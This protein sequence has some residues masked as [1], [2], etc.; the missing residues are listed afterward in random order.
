MAQ[1][2]QTLLVDDIDGSPAKETVRFS[3]DGAEYEI[4]V[5]SEHGEELR[6]A[7]AL[8]IAH[9]RKTRRTGSARNA[10]RASQGTTADVDPAAAR[11]WAIERGKKVNPR[12]RVPAHIVAEYLRDSE[13]S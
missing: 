9:A 1:K 4:D 13:K 11:A 2:I 6:E 7:L 3:L 10:S 8:Y 12:G 5:N